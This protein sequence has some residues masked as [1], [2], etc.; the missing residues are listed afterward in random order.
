MS[1]KIEIGS[2]TKIMLLKVLRNGYFEQD[3]L[4]D[5]IKYIYS[6]LSDEELNRQINELCRKLGVPP[7]ITIEVIDRRE[8]VND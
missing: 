8:Q 4:E 1:G 7:P 5:L 3:T 6:D 2:K